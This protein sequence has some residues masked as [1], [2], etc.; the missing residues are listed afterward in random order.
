MIP[1]VLSLAASFQRL[2]WLD[3]TAIGLDK[4]AVGADKM[5]TGRSLIKRPSGRF[6][7]K[8]ARLLATNGLAWPLINCLCGIMW[9]LPSVAQI[10]ESGNL[11]LMAA[12]K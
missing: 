4:M 6:S 3:K 9:N 8:E 2:P 7:L 1:E 11:A 10:W 5:A 12:P